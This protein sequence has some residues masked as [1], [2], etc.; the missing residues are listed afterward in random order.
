MER[1]DFV[2]S[3]V[4]DRKNGIVPIDSNGRMRQARSL[5]NEGKRLAARI[6]K[7]EETIATLQDESKL[8][9]QGIQRLQ[10]RAND[11][12]L[13]IQERAKAQAELDA[14]V[15]ERRRIIAENLQGRDSS[16]L[17]SSQMKDDGFDPA[18]IEECNPQ[19]GNTKYPRTPKEY[20]RRI[21][22]TTNAI[23]AAEAEAQVEVRKAS[24]V[25]EKNA[26]KADYA[27]K[28]A[29]LVLELREAERGYYSTA[30]GLKELKAEVD[31]R[32][33][34]MTV[35]DRARLRRRYEAALARHDAEQNDVRLRKARRR[36]ILRAY[37][38]AGKDPK[39]ALAALTKGSKTAV[40]GSVSRSRVPTELRYT[41]VRKAMLT[42][43]EDTRTYDRFRESGATSYAA[44]KREQIMASP[45]ALFRDKTIAELNATAER[46]TDGGW[47]RQRTTT[48][49]LRD[50]A[51]ETAL[52]GVEA[53][54]L[55]QRAESF[56]MTVSSYQRCMLL[57]IDPRR[58]QNDRSD[59]TNDTKTAMMESMMGEIRHTA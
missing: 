57:N 49:G 9:P 48:D 5:Q 58:I 12:E 44:W 39:H 53:R 28:V 41:V 24:T 19:I 3:L 17:L 16:T 55:K 40:G 1:Y 51:V 4:E 46:F 11:A 42:A 45:T 36:N 2:K 38:E 14:A 59:L 23:H 22:N 15:A 30:Q 54:V 29:S 18:T 43:N 31:D 37:K 7:S 20:K 50:V 56:H 6:A 47:H 25:D 21:Q 33:V 34:K 52:N 26:V 8:T 27:N 10:E 13:S 32:S 35:M